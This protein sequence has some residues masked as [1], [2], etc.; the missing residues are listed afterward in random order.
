[1]KNGITRKLAYGFS[2]AFHSNY[3]R[4]L[5]R[6]DT[7]QERDGQRDRHRTTAAVLLHSIARQKQVSA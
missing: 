3:G 5:S 4:I 1:M 6:V 7:I 2:F